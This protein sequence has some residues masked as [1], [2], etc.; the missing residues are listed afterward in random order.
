MCL[1][2]NRLL[3]FANPDGSLRNASSPKRFFS[4]VD[5]ISAMEGNGPVAGTRRMAGLI[6]AGDNPVAVDAVCARLMGFDQARLPLLNRSLEPH[7]FP[8][9]QGSSD[10]I[11]ITGN[12]P[13]W[14]RPLSQWSLSD[15]LKFKPHF[16]WTGAVEMK[17]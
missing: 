2:L 3:M 10:D 12:V 4:V 1:D 7:R 11:T 16:G 13:G 5:G 6:V 8:L 15:T 9:F 17:P 14:N